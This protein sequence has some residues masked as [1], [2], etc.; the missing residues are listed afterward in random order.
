MYSMIHSA[1]NK[2]WSTVDYRQSLAFDTTYLLFNN[3]CDWWLFPEIFFLLILFL[4]PRNSFEGSW[5]CF[6]GI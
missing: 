4:F 1:A 5:T 2:G 6:N 3:N